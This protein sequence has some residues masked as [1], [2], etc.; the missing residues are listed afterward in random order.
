MPRECDGRFD[1]VELPAR[2]MS[3][4]QRCKRFYS[5]PLRRAFK[6]WCKGHLDGRDSVV[7]N[8]IDAD[9]ERQRSHL[10]P[11]YARDLEEIFENIRAAGCAI[12]RDMFAVLGRPRFRFKDP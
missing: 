5:E 3:E 9:A 4:L 10:H 1:L 8:G 12:T 11:V 6:E 2:G 7:S